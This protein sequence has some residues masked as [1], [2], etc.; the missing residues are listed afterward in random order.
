MAS[1]ADAI[2]MFMAVEFL[3]RVPTRESCWR[4]VVMMGA[5]TTSYKFALAKSLIGLSIT[6]KSFISL[7]ELAIPFSES[8]CEHIQHHAKQGKNPTNTFLD[9]C[10]KRNTGDISEDVLVSETVKRGFRY[11]FDRFHHVNNG[12]MPVKF[13]VDESKDKSGITL[14]DDFFRLSEGNQFNN[15]PKEVEARWNLV[16]TAWDL[17]TSANLLDI[18]YDPDQTRLFVRRKDTRRVDVTSCRDALNAYQ[19]GKCFYCFRAISVESGNDLLGD[20]DHFLPHKLKDA[21]EIGNLDGVWNLVLSCI[22]CNRKSK[23]AMVPDIR[24]LVRLNTRNDF[25]ISSHHPLRETLIRQTG[26]NPQARARFLNQSRQ[27][28]LQELIHT[29]EPIEEFD[30]AF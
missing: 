14:T 9:A 19:K 10:Q 3:E 23:R 1:L 29:W 11:V 30:T 12:E 26:N 13:F 20:V 17:N 8:I 27:Q 6:G 18:E 28:A 16:E 7:E 5:N 2:I 15:L 21:R 22:T 24:Y 4:S 25:L